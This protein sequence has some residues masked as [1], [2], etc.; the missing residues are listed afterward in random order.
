MAMKNISKRRGRRFPVA[1]LCV[2]AM[3]NAVTAGASP[4]QESNAS[5]V[6]VSSNVMGSAAGDGTEP[7]ALSVF[8]FDPKN[9]ALQPVQQLPGPSPTWI[10]IHP[11]QQ[12]L[13]ACYSLR[14]KDKPR[15]ALVESYRIEPA[16]GELTL[17]DRR[18]LDAGTAHLAVAPDGR[19]LVLANYYYGD[20]AVLP[21]GEDGRLG[22]VSGTLPGAPEDAP[23]GP[24]S[25]Q[26]G[27]HPHAVVFDPGERFIGTADLGTDKLHAL[28]LA[29]DA[30]EPVSEVSVAKG[31]GPRHIAF[32]RNGKAI[33]AIG[34]LDGKIVVLG[35]D[36]ATGKIGKPLQTVNAYPAGFSGQP[37]AAELLVHPSGKFLYA[38]ERASRSI[39]A[40]RI[41]PASGTL[42]L[43]GSVT[44]GIGMPN[45]F[46]IDPG[47]QWLYAPASDGNSVAQFS[48]DPAT[49]SLTPTGQMTPVPAPNV[50][51]FRKAR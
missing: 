7:A 6:Y 14:D 50:M 16:S 2:A 20:Y 3:L 33:Y 45:S 30:L 46:G 48:I 18:T 27:S 43:I 34:E 8:K 23:R 12:F 9:G 38:S 39:T 36:A 51:V 29:G 15:I 1:G 49:G 4:M 25:R 41:A 17:L 35:Y 31:M 19:H 42:S 5:Y 47:G 22:A 44:Q 32:A 28:R 10:A 26:D 37:S 13:F 11:S 24:H 21:I 40:Y